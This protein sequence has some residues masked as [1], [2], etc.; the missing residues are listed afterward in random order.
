MV[1]DQDCTDLG[2]HKPQQSHV[3]P[4]VEHWESNQA[5][6]YAEYVDIEGDN[7]VDKVTNLGTN[8]Q[9]QPL[10]ETQANGIVLLRQCMLTPPKFSNVRS[11]RQGSKGTKDQPQPTE[12]NL[13]DQVQY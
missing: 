13:W 8:L 3:H 6:T 4:L 1:P 5:S 12:K 10:G 11:Y 2:S 9:K 7:G